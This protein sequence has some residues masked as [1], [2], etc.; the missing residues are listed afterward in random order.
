VPSSAAS[1]GAFCAISTPY[2]ANLKVDHTRLV[3][4]ATDLLSRG[5]DGIALFGSTG[6]GASIGLQ[7]RQRAFSALADAGVELRTHVVGAIIASAAEEALV[8]SQQALD[9][10]CRGLLV[11]PPCY[12]KGLSEEGLFAWFAHLIEDL[13]ASARDIILYHIPALTSVPLA[14]TLVERLKQNFPGVIIGVKDSS[15]DWRQTERFLQDH[16]DLAILVG[17]ERHLARALRLG[18]AGTICG[19]ANC[20]PEAIGQIVHAGSDD[21]RVSALVGEI[22]TLPIMAA[23]K[24]LVAHCRN[25]P[26]WTRMRPPLAALNHAQSTALCSSFE[27]LFMPMPTASDRV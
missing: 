24:T 23:I 7:P 13:G 20:A 18:G 2:L 25:D 22:V 9:E 5:C 10:N 26:E 1:F 6:E 15:G 11:A 19:V 16:S 17:D 8:L 3:S 12:Y 21:Q 4:H 27:R 14:P